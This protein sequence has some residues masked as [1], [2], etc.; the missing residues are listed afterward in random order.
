MNWPNRPGQSITLR[1]NRAMNQ[2]RDASAQRAAPG[3]AGKIC[4]NAQREQVQAKFSM[5]EL[6]QKSNFSKKIVT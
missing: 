1:Q 3:R 5:F 2:K 6:Q 4:G